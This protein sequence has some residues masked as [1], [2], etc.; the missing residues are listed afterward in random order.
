MLCCGAL[1]ILLILFAISASVCAIIFPVF[2]KY[3]K[4]YEGLQTLLYFWEMVGK[5]EKKTNVR[6]SECYEYSLHFQVALGSMATSA[7]IGLLAL[8][9][10][11]ALI[12]L[13]D[14]MRHIKIVSLSL[15]FFAFLASGAC[16]ALLVLGYF[17]GYCQDNKSL[18]EKYKSFRGREF[19]FDI[20]LYLAA[21]TCLLYLLGNVTHCCI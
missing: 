6:D 20:G 5:R 7:V 3:S 9:F 4:N 14:K 1:A 12:V 11:I 17:R 15:L 21:T 19:K 18:S 2:C 13:K 10:V 16:V 8:M